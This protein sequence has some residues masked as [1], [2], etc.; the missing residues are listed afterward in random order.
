VALQLDPALQSRWEPIRFVAMD[1]VNNCNLRCPF[2]VYDYDKVHTT[3]VM[4]DEVY[5]AVLKLLPLVG[6]ECLWLSCLHE[7]TMHPKFAELIERIPREY[8]SKVFYTSNFAR[9]MP[10]VYYDTLADSGIRHV[11]ISIE[12]RDPAV[13]ERMRKG[14][15]H[16]I[17]MESWEKLLAACASGSAPPKL[18]YIIMAYQSNLREIPELV[19]YLRNER[20]ASHV[21]VRHTFDQA[22]IPADFR[23]SE[24]LV[25]AD[26]RW[27]QAKLADHA[28]HDLT[29]WPPPGFVGG[30]SGP[31]PTQETPAAPTS[32]S[33]P[34]FERVPG[35]FTV[36]IFHDG[37][38]A[39]APSLA[40]A[41]ARGGEQ[42]V[43]TNVTKIGDP[44]EFLM[45][46]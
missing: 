21:E 33:D 17:F 10:N 7:P 14:A 4:T 3:K 9:R 25:D 19:E 5:D 46:L 35:M 38:M 29:F 30:E 44:V 27:L 31:R 13:Y 34:R 11:N 20:L 24:Y 15:R 8:R 41:S 32:A 26:W 45:S 37:F 28:A 36:Q 2:C 40:G 39:V 6:P 23:A 18:R 12:S 16:H 42:F 22:H 43:H 1:I